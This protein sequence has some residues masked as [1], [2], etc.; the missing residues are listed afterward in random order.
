MNPT[1]PNEDGLTFA[2]WQEQVDQHLHKLCGLGASDLADYPSYDLWNDSCP[3]PR[4]QRCAWSSGTT[5]PRTCSR[6][7][8]D[9]ALPSF[10]LASPAAVPPRTAPALAGSTPARGTQHHERRSHHVPV[11]DPDRPPHVP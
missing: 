10:L 4:P 8:P 11:R 9:E 7:T 1:N 5:T 2:Q 6:A 3:P